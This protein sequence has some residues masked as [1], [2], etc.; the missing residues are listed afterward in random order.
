[1][2]YPDMKDVLGLVGEVDLSFA[3]NVLCTYPDAVAA[4]HRDGFNGLIM[5]RNGELIYSDFDTGMERPLNLWTDLTKA[6]HSAN[7]WKLA[8]KAD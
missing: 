3:V 1:M 7:N 6:D 4:I 8:V 2:K 5:R